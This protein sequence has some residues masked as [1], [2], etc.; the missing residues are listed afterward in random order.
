[1]IKWLCGWIHKQGAAYTL[2]KAEAAVGNPPLR[3][4]RDGFPVETDG[5]HFHLHHAENGRILRVFKTEQTNQH[6]PP[7]EKIYIISDGENV[8]DFVARAIA[9]E[10]IK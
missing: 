5:M 8:M 7:L 6:S 10:R 2:E 3:R 1:M 9:E 4:R